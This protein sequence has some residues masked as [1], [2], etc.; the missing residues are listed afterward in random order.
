MVIDMRKVLLLLL[1]T[2]FISCKMTPQETAEANV[3]TY[4][5]ANILHPETYE[6]IDFEKIEKDSVSEY[7]LH[8]SHLYR[9]K[10]KT[11]DMVVSH[12]VFF[13]DSNYVVKK[14]ITLKEY[15]DLIK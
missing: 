5:L 12:R 13:L 1:L 2:V 9:S 3:K 11:G 6:G 14:E 7:P 8:I 10:S 4:M 15:N